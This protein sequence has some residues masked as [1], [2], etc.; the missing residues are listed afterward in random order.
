MRMAAGTRKAEVAGLQSGMK[1]RDERINREDRHAQM[2]LHGGSVRPHV[3]VLANDRTDIRMARE[4][5]FA[6][7]E[8]IALGLRVIRVERADPL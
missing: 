3:V 6:G 2:S 1:P 4:Q 8:N 7:V 5:R